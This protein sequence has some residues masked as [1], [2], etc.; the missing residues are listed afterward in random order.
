MKIFNQLLFHNNTQKFQSTFKSKVH[1]IDGFAHAGNMEHFAK[2]SLKKASTVSDVQLHYVNCNSIDV[3]TKQMDDVES[4]LKSLSNTLNKG[5]FLA[6]PGLASVS[7]LNLQDRISEVLGK[8]VYLTVKNLKSYKDTLLNYLKEIYDYK[9]YY[10]GDI[11]YLDRNGQKLEYTYGVIKEINKLQNKGVNVY[12]PAG[13][14]ADE[15][16]KWLAKDSGKS[17]ELYKYVAT[18]NDSGGHVRDIFR[19]AEDNRYYDFN[20]LSLSDAHIV[21]IKGKNGGE[22]L[23]SSKDGYANDGA[24]GV[25]N[26]TPVRNSYGRILGYSY[27]D[28]TT[29]EYP[30][31]EFPANDKIANL[32][33]YVGLPRSDF[34]ASFSEDRKFKE[35]LKKGYS[36][37]SLS[38]K[39]YALKDVYDSSEIENKNLDTLGSLV[40]RDGLIFDTNRQG[41]IIFQKTNCE[42]SEKPSVLQMWGSCFSAINALVRDIKNGGAEKIVSKD[43]SSAGFIAQADKY[44]ARGDYSAAESCY[45]EALDIL[46]PNKMSFNYQKEAIETYEKLYSVLRSSYK[47][48]EAKGIANMLINLYSNEIKDLSVFDT[49]YIRIQS[50]IGDYYNDMADYCEREY[51]YYPARVCRWA[52]EELKKSSLNGDKIVQRRAEQNQYIG[53]LYDACH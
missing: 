36:T 33:K 37:S 26:F 51:E 49:R 11:K 41:K 6:I 8:S 23:F 7:V 9:N 15:T 14:G 12:L 53:D 39:L 34:L 30:Y 5:D 42:G 47:Y 40:N 29:V 24:R 46:H 45:N 4:M 50:K 48:N 28:E 1:I 16:I 44:K 43:F 20:L 32:C 31:S 22:Y 27:H 19:R 13:H 38:D 17:D 25:Y 35:Y 18:G 52:V 2:A 3:N 21:N 10:S